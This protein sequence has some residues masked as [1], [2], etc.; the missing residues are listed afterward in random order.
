MSIKD[1]NSF[2]KVLSCKVYSFNNIDDFRANNPDLIETG[3]KEYFKVFFDSTFENSYMFYNMEKF[4]EVSNILF[5]INHLGAAM[6]LQLIGNSNCTPFHCALLEI[7][8]RG[9]VIGGRGDTGKST[10]ASRIPP[11]HR[12]LADDYA[13]IY[14][15]EG[16]ILAQAMPTWS[17]YVNGDTEYTA[18]C[19][20]IVEVDSFFFLR[21]SPDDYVE[22]INGNNAAQYANTAMQDL[23]KVRL[24]TDMPEDL[25]N[26]FRT[27]VF[28][29]AQR[30]VKLKPTYVLH[31][32]LHGDFW[33]KMDEVMKQR[34]GNKST[35]K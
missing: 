30:L 35:N 29:F 14:E 23:L 21:Q 1:P 17:N 5:S 32:T 33:N 12:A 24:L 16:K 34:N 10:C 8:S 18:D 4:K 22:P 31:A 27:K 9:A 13:M 20:Q 25:K 26:Y 2:D 6:Q 7:N 19:S 3:R 28:D 11:P 15:H